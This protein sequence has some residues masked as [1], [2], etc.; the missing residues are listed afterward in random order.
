MPVFPRE[1]CLHEDL[2]HVYECISWD[3][4]TKKYTLVRDDNQT[5]FVDADEFTVISDASEDLLQA[6]P[7]GKFISVQ[8]QIDNQ[9]SFK[10]IKDRGPSLQEAAPK[11]KARRD[12]GKSNDPIKN[13][14]R[15]IF[16]H[17][18]SRED[19]AEAAGKWLNVTPIVLL[20]QYEHLDNGRF[21]MVCGNK[22]R[23]L[24][25]TQQAGG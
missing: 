23:S 17:C 22:I 12:L 2:E 10:V 9:A 15:E 8:D 16:S 5:R 4:L 20:Q 19:V 25:K 6:T 7:D 1:V 24:L 11:P 21:R 18:E 3:P 13:Q 14:V